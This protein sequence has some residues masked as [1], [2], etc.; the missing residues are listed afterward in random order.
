M[1]HLHQNEIEW[2]WKERKRK[3]ERK[4]DGFKRQCTCHAASAT[5][6]DWMYL[7]LTPTLTT[8]S[9]RPTVKGCLTSKWEILTENTMPTSKLSRRMFFQQISD[10]PKHLK[11][12]FLIES[13]YMRSWSL[14]RIES[15]SVACTNRTKIVSFVCALRKKNQI[16]VF[17]SSIASWICTHD[18]YLFRNSLK[19]SPNTKLIRGQCTRTIN[20]F[21]CYAVNW[22]RRNST[23]VSIYSI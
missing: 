6:F 22:M 23:F 16:V 7:I 9:F 13:P 17:V 3:K 5:L 2:R 11:L 10:I 20:T 1:I 14:I 12:E 18:F 21:H 8:H 15:H 4:S 19:H